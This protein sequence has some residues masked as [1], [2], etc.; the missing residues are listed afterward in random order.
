VNVRDADTCQTCEASIDD[1]IVITGLPFVDQ[2][3]FCP[4][5]DLGYRGIRGAVKG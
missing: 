2:V 5:G 1:P 3:S 4:T